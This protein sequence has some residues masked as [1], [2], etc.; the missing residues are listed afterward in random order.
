[1]SQIEKGREHSQVIDEPPGPVYG[2]T[3]TMGGTRNTL[4]VA[5]LLAATQMVSI[6]WLF[7]C[8][9]SARKRTRI[10]H[11][12]SIPPPVPE[13]VHSGVET[14]STV[15]PLLGEEQERPARDHC[16]GLRARVNKARAHHRH[17]VLERGGHL[18]GE[19]GAILRMRRQ[20]VGCLRMNV[21]HTDVARSGIKELSSSEQYQ[22]E[23]QCD[24]SSLEK[25]NT[26]LLTV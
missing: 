10:H 1:M 6:S 7:C 25:E 5:L 20:H 26:F 12:V 16:P 24:V 17:A 22:H 4:S 21:S 9:T 3:G 11:Q 19:Q 14:G 13:K 15:G 23:G 8:L 18:G 2:H